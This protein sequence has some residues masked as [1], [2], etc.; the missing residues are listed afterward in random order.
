LNRVLSDATKSEHRE[1]LLGS[2]LSIGDID[3]TGDIAYEDR[4]WKNYL[5]LNEKSSPLLWQEKHYRRMIEELA[6]FQPDILEANPSY[7]WHLCRY[8]SQHN[9]SLHQPRAIIYTYELPFAWQKRWIQRVF[10]CPCASSY[11]S[12]ELGYVFMEC[13]Y[14]RLHQNTRFVRV[15]FQ[16]LAPEH[17]G[18]DMGRIL[19]TT[20][21]NPWYQIVRFDPGDIVRLSEAPCAC[22]GRE[23]FVLEAIEGRF[24]YCTQDYRGR[25][26][27]PR[28]LD[29][30]MQGVDGISGYSLVQE[31][32]GEYAIRV[33]ADKPLSQ[34]RE[35]IVTALQRVYGIEAKFFVEFCDAIQP[36]PSGKFCYSRSKCL[37]DI[38]HFI[39]TR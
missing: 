38:N 32:P 24:A 19:V 10:D 11:G 33:C 7:L 5:F 17:G 3:D 9:V 13:P 28:R 37:P 14:G 30:A 26:I 29:A 2:A 16:P 21:G 15:D 23:G 34:A 27:T 22:G 35:E 8:A 39:R 31:A 12:T 20:F 4:L 25:L 6:R 1:A 18:H 36:E